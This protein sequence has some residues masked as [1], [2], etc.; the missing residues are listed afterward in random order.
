[1]IYYSKRIRSNHS[2]QKTHGLNSGENQAGASKSSLPG[3][4]Y[5]MH[6]IPPKMSC[7]NMCLAEK[8]ISNSVPIIFT[9][10]PSTLYMLKFH[11]L[12]RKAVGFYKPYLYKLFSCS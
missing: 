3:D 1:M 12:R 9:G 2:K 8:F 4:S 5:Q 10:T 11:V 6:L 7:D